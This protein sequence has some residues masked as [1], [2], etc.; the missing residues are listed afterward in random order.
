MRTALALILLLSS[1]V[2]APASAKVVDTCDNRRAVVVGLPP[3]AHLAPPLEENLSDM[4]AGVAHYV[5]ATDCDPILVT[6]TSDLDAAKKVLP[7]WHLPPWA[8][9]AARPEART[10]LLTVHQNG[11]PTNRVRVL[12][13][14]LSHLAIASAAGGNKL[15][16][17]FD[18]GIS[19]TIAREDGP[20]DAEVLN[21]ARAFSNLMGLD[22]LRHAFPADKTL[23]AVAYA[24]SARAISYLER[25]HGGNIVARLLE[26][27]RDGDAFDDALLE[28]TGETPGTITREIE[29]ELRPFVAFLAA[30][31]QV[32]LGLAFGGSFFFF[33]GFRAR[34]KIREQIEAM[35]DDEPPPY[36]LDDVVTARWLA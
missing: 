6:L 1:F 11:Q 2:A 29:N 14:E 16:R 15:P 22:E 20:P 13:H 9:G 32:D 28:L 25:T 27:V 8:A 21:R 12:R 17:W 24:E 30:F 33:A 31:W 18:E 7:R 10:I 34:R 3:V 35:D 5:G 19:R 23:A 4:Y 36:Q 26:K